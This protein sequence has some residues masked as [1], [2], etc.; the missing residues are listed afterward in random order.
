ML[1][2]E[3]VLIPV[4][5][6]S[7][8]RQTTVATSKAE[9]EYVGECNAAKESVILADSLKGIGYQGSDADN[10]L[11]LADNQA[12]IKLAN[13]PVNHPR[14]KHIDIQYHK[15]RELISDAVLELDYIETLKM[16]A[17]GLTKPLTL[18]K[19]KYFITMFGLAE[20]SEELAQIGAKP[21]PTPTPPA[22]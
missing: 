4:I 16:V 1:C 22:T 19:H 10:V 20:K 17:D 8:K 6:W 18:V 5:S 12:T 7:S 2:T 21:A 11:L 14:A 3:I 9:A 13:N 15:V